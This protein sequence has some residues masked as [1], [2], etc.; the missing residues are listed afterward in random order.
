MIVR[1]YYY[2]LG[3]TVCQKKVVKCKN[4]PS[5]I[6]EV[7]ARSHISLRARHY[8]EMCLRVCF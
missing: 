7:S 2:N 1:I 3:E 8:Y 6:K 4:E 5:G